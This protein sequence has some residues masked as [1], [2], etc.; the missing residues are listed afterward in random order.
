MLSPAPAS[1]PCLPVSRY[2]LHFRGPASSTGFAGNHW[3]GALGHSLR[4]RQCLTGAPTC[5]GCSQRHGCDYAYLFD[6]PVPK[7][8]AKMRRYAEAPHPYTLFEST[9]PRQRGFE[10]VATLEF[11]LLGRAGAHA[12]A[13]AGALIDAAAAPPGIGGR[14]MA[15][16]AWEGERATGSDTWNAIA[17]EA[18]HAAAVTAAVADAAWPA[19]PSQGWLTIEL[20]SPLRVR[21]E[22]RTIGPHVFAFADLFGNLLRR[23]SMLTYFHAATALETDF[24]GLID[25]ARRID[26]E[27][28]LR[29]CHQ[30]RFSARQQAAMTMDGVIGQLRLPIDDALRP[31]WPYL[32]LGQFTHVGS[33]ATMGMGRYRLHAA[34]SLPPTA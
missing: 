16:L 18:T 5:T 29:W 22:G 14:R 23:I 34:A 21:R 26:A 20:L 3:R 11:T 10:N 27:T 33:G 17:T 9:A 15:L 7:D 24:R 25:A 31:F 28:A 1:E 8:S 32:W 6:T 13:F 4:V 12:A 19:A 2:R 30:S